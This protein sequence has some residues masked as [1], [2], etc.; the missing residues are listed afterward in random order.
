MEKLQIKNL[1]VK[2]IYTSQIR[3]IHQSSV[4]HVENEKKQLTDQVPEV[5][6][7]S[8]LDGLE[9]MKKYSEQ[10]TV[11]EYIEKTTSSFEE[12]F[13]N[14]YKDE[15]VKQFLK[16]K[17]RQKGY[18]WSLFTTQPFG[19]PSYMHVFFLTDHIYACSIGTKRAFMKI[20]YFN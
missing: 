16:E 9:E 15:K 4:L 17:K 5:D 6:T 3:T 11:S 8:L 10:M 18:K 2:F 19:Y 1:Q 12:A 14:F 13:P 20:F 7:K